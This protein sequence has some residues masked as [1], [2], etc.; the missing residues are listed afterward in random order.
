[1]SKHFF[2]ILFLN[3]VFILL[4]VSKS[5][6]EIM[7]DTAWVRGFNGSGNTNDCAIAM[8]SSGSGNICVIGFSAQTSISPYS[9]EFATILYDT[10]GN[11]L[12]MRRYSGLKNY[13]SWTSAATVDNYYNLYLT[14]YCAQDT[15]YPHNYDYVTAKFLS[16]GSIA[17]IKKY[18][19]SGNS[20]DYA[21]AIT[22]DGQSN[23]YVTGKSYSGLGS[24]DDYVT[25]KYFSNGDMAWMKRYNGPAN[26]TDGACAIA[27]DDLGNVYVTGYSYSNITSFDYATIK[28]DA[29]GNQLWIKRYNGSANSRDA[30]C[31]LTVDKYGNVFVTGGSFDFSTNY[32]CVTVKYDASGNELWVK[33]YNG[34]E[35][36]DDWAYA[37]A[38]DISGYIGVAGGSYGDGGSSDYLTVKYDSRGNQ[39]W[40][41]RY[42]RPGNSSDCANALAFDGSGNVYVTGESYGTGTKQFDFTTIKYN[43]AFALRGDVNTDGFID[44]ADAVYLINYLYYGQ[45]T[46]LPFEIV[47]DCNCDEVVDISDI[48][49]L[50]NHVFYGGITPHCY[51]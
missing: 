35:N 44:L 41:K 7:V 17:W 48:I 19:G 10:F 24:S 18:N 47:G 34:S 26:S 29:Y 37:I 6:S 14:G 42:N 3:I 25:I 46:P 43:E 20:N 51:P 12:W 1:V 21:S 31:A 8:K 39:L 38:I 5:F 23:I 16:N 50:I 28:Y 32:D 4:G 9:Y 33:K 30:A 49:F 11:Q 22:V 45:S 40:A 36:G 27:V 2:L 13:L 15:A